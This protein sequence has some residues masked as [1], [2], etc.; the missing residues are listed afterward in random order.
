MTERAQY[1]QKV[2]LLQVL[3]LPI[4]IAGVI[5]LWSS[6]FVLSEAEQV[7]ITQFGEPIGEPITNAGLHFKVPFTQE[8]NRLDHRALEWDGS[9]NEMPTKDKTYIIVDTFARWRISDPKKFFLRIR[10]ERSAQSRLEDILGSETRNAIA[11]RELIEVVRTDKNRVP[12]KDET[13]DDENPTLGTLYP[14][15]HGR[16]VIKHEIFAAASDKL[17]EFGI[18]LLDVSF[19]RINYNPTVQRRIYDRMIS[20]RKQIADRFRSEGAGEAAR[21]IGSKEKELQKIK[22]E[23]YKKILLIR[24]QADA[25]ATEI[26]ASAYNQNQESIDFYSF[27]QAMETLRSALKEDSQLVFSMNNPLFRYLSD[28]ALPTKSP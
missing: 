25:K 22:S 10:D 19:K 4:I 12:A 20:E 16:E 6:A 14:I 11:K 7:I 21:I 2:S 23:A 13:T 15:H 24:G 1:P 26:Y 5:T 18:E 17:K 8:V 28:E 27:L 3:S 9:P